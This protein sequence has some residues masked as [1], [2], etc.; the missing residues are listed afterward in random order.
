[1]QQAPQAEHEQ[2]GVGGPQLA[3]EGL[4]VFDP[5]AP[6]LVGVG[7]ADAAAPEVIPEGAQGLGV[8]PV[9]PGLG[10]GAQG[11]VEHTQAAQHRETQRENHL[12]AP[13]S[14]APQ[15]LDE[16]GHQQQD[17]EAQ[18]GV[19]AG[20]EAHQQAE[21]EGVAAVPRPQAQGEPESGGGEEGQARVD[22]DG[23]GVQGEEAGGPGGEGAQ[24]RGRRCDA[25]PAGRRRQEGQG[26]RPQQPR[27]EGPA[28]GR[29]SQGQSVHDQGVELGVHGEARGVGDAQLEGGRPQLTGVE[30]GQGP[31]RTQAEADASECK[32]RR[33]RHAQR[34]PCRA[35]TARAETVPATRLA[36]T[37]TTAASSGE[38]QAKP[39]MKA[40]PTRAMGSSMGRF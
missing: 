1:V 3:Q 4:G 18:L 25:Q 16:G 20:G 28:E 34:R 8:A 10:G 11:Q 36:M 39:Q 38:L 37:N 27:G 30:P 23:G 12:A 7:Q 33:G 31:R 22:L 29:G 17:E 6:H 32:D 9:A 14:A 15:A 35:R 19:V 26:H 2:G 13:S 21:G 40:R 24:G 5:Q